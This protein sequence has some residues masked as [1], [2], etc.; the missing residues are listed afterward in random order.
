MTRKKEVKDPVG[1]KQGRATGQPSQGSLGSTIAFHHAR[2]LGEAHI[3]LRL[4][5]LHIQACYSWV[6]LVDA[7][8]QTA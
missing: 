2:G 8:L 5:Y 6:I 3:V 1:A 4:F 7:T